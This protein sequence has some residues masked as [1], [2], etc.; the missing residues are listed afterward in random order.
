VAPERVLVQ[1]SPPTPR[2]ET[3]S[4]ARAVTPVRAAGWPA[5]VA[6]AARVAARNPTTATP[7]VGQV[8]TAPAAG[9]WVPPEA[10]AA[11]AERATPSK[12]GPAK[13]VTVATEATGAPAARAARPA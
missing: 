4:A 8:E 5:T 2:S 3:R 12:A 1:H 10:T 9:V 11:P 7:P 6:R 13:A